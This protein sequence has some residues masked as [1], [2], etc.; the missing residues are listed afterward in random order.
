MV[1][2][3][4]VSLTGIWLLAL[5]I[6]GEVS[7]A[8]DD[9]EPRVMEVR[10]VDV[11]PME[12]VFEPSDLTVRPGDIVRFVQAGVMPHNVEFRDVPAGADLGDARLGPYLMSKGQVYELV[13]DERFTAGAYPYV[14]TP[15]E[16]MGMKGTLTVVEDDS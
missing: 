12:F 16:A 15:H 10:M 5:A 1:R 13:I 14:C 3:W 2:A 7:P 11:S 4:T 6:P 8:V 9:P